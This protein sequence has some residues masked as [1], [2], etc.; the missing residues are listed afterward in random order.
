M[1]IVHTYLTHAHPHKTNLDVCYCSCVL[2]LLTVMCLLRVCIMCINYVHYYTLLRM[3][4]M[5]WSLL[6]TRA[7]RILQETGNTFTLTV[8]KHAADFY[9]ISYNI[10]S[11]KVSSLERQGDHHG[12]HQC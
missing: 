1:Y 4:H 10:P 2:I 11:T 12:D 3:S 6:H 5:I 8:A 9:G 7:V